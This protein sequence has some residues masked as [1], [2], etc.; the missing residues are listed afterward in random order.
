MNSLPLLG[1]VTNKPRGLCSI[2]A[3]RY[4]LVTTPTG[5]EWTHPDE[6]PPVDPLYFVKR[7]G[8]FFLF[9]YFPLYAQR[10][11]GC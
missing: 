2:K 7:V 4:L 8:G 6:A 10:R 3:L 5:A 9:C 11:E 1:V